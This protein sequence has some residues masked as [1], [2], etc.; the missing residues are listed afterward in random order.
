LAVRLDGQ[1]KKV[2]NDKNCTYYL[3]EE[4]SGK[5][6]TGLIIIIDNYLHFFI[7]TNFHLTARGTFE[8]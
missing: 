3:C 2:S 4:V 7:F 6:S 1:K 8:K 5:Q